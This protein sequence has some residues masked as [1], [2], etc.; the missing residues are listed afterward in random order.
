MFVPDSESRGDSGSGF[1]FDTKNII[2]N[3]AGIDQ[4]L[5]EEQQL[6]AVIDGV[7][8]N[9]IIGM[10][11]HLAKDLSAYGIRVVSVLPSGFKS[12]E[13]NQTVDGYRFA[14]PAEF[15]FIVQ[16]LVLNGY[17]NCDSIELNGGQKLRMI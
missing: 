4:H 5:S 11:K 16:S 1:N 3:T 9:A 15:G 13:N 2:I 8:T 7:T 17:V 14:N 10:T 6:G 12:T